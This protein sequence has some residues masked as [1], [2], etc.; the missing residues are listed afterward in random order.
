[1][2]ST[3]SGFEVI[4]SFSSKPSASIRRVRVDEFASAIDAVSVELNDISVT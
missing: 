4:W 3:A 2:S 1:V